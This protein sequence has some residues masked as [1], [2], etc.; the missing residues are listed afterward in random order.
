MNENELSNVVIGGAIEIHQHLGPGLLENAYHQCL[1]RE[2]SL[3]DI[4]FETEKAIP[5]EYK[6]IRLDCGYRLDFLIESKLILELKAVDKILPIHEAQM[7][8]YLKLTGCKLGLILNFN[9]A[10]LRE[11]IKRLALD[12]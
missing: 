6:G 7:L 8:T 2:L 3:R 9:V 4:E 10:V 11:G 1:A 12:L 5:L